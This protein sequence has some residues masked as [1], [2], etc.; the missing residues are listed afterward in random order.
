MGRP[1]RVCHV[2][3]TLGTG[4]RKRLL[5]GLARH[6]NREICQ[7][8]FLALADGGRFAEEIRDAGCDVLVLGEAAEEQIHKQQA[9]DR[10][11]SRSRL[12]RIVQMRRR[13]A[14]R[15]YD[16]VH[17]H[18][19]YPHLYATVAA[20]WAGVPVVIN[21][22]HGQ[23]VGHGWKSRCLFRLASRWVDRIVAVSDDAARL[24]VQ[25]DGIPI[26]KVTRIW[27][28][29][30]TQAFAESAHRREPIAI[31]VARLS[32]EKDFPTL[33]AAIVL[34]QRFVPNLRLRIV[35]DGPER[36]R[37]QSLSERLGI[38]DRVQ[39]LGERTD[40][41]QQL[42]EAGFFVTSSRSEGISLTLLEAMACGLP[43]VATDVGGNA[44]IVGDAALGQL[45]P[46]ANPKRLAEAIVELCGRV[47]QWPAMG[48]AAR[49]SVAQ[50]FDAR[51]M[52][53]DYEQLYEQLCPIR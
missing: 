5:A 35:G 36:S 24:C 38:A 18:N 11:V 12:S 13:F 8:E 32:P 52:V 21:T 46:P 43:V 22:R 40:V 51:R 25:V 29:I 26:H 42:A 47:D 37:L 17:T 45:V 27:N 50:R 1:V 28:G 2:S 15:R 7:L 33:L 48:S 4:G 41:A 6:H 14:D 10:E 19:I 20:R 16:I 39:F 30:D 23:R 44:E 9:V 3:L 34:A 31:S 49:R 53:S